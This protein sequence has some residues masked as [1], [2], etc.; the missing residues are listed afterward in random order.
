[1]SREIPDGVY[2]AGGA[3][4]GSVAARRRCGGLSLQEIRH[5]RPAR[6]PEHSH[7]RAFICLVVAGGYTERVGR[8]TET[9]TP[10]SALF[11][12]PAKSHQDEIGRTG[13]RFF[14]VEI[15]GRWIDRI[16]E[17]APLPESVAEPRGGDLVWLATRLYREFRAFDA[18]SPL[19]VEGLVLEALAV[20]ARAPR[21]DERPAPRWL[22]RA[23][24]LLRDGAPSEL[25]T[26]RVAAEAGV[27]P[28]HFARVFRREH[29]CTVGEYVRRQRVRHALGLLSDTSL[30]L[31]E[32][33][34]AAGFADQSHLTR[35]FRQT[36]GSTP[37]ALRSA[38]AD[39]RAADRPSARA[40]S[41]ATGVR[42]NCPNTES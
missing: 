29:G 16:R 12:P 8:R 17:V 22:G 18:W 27:H 36:L 11:H 42:S 5:A 24:E 41:H 7:E 26:A 4:Y 40:P 30:P 39:A 15:D 31:A 2:L 19:A 1:M 21:A 6:L 10:F 3:Y 32:V 33:A 25:T 23:T 34:L 14:S 13:A 28:V 20:A 38:L 9:Y 37:G 35:V